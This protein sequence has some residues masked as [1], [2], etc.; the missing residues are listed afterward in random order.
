ML[1]YDFAS[2]LTHSEGSV[3]LASLSKMA[4]AEAVQTKGS[5]R[6]VVGRDVAG[7]GVFEIGDGFEDAAPDFSPGDGREESLDGVEP[8]RGG[9]GEVERP[10]RMVGEPFQDV[11]LFVGGVVV[12]RWRG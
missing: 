3:I 12:E 9:G 10:S 5:G 4:L 1:H 6:L 7:D 2:A 8:R 11:G